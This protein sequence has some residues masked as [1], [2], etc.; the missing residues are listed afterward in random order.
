MTHSVCQVASY[1]TAQLLSYKHQEG[2]DFVAQRDVEIFYN[3]K[4]C[5]ETGLPGPTVYSL[6]TVCEQ[7]EFI[8]NAFRIWPALIRSMVKHQGHMESCRNI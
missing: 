8:H 2:D 6:Q 3:C 4:P 5:R 7:I 1:G